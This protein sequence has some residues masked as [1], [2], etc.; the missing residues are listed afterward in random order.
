MNVIPISQRGR[1]LIVTRSVVAGAADP[2]VDAV[3]SSVDARRLTPL[4][5]PVITA[6]R[7]TPLGPSSDAEELPQEATAM[8]SRIAES[9]LMSR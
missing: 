2:V 1:T 8:A 7:E 4:T 6:P 9:S 5:R 3:P